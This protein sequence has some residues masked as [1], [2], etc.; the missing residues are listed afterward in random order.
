MMIGM[1]IAYGALCLRACAWL[2]GEAGGAE[3][4][5]TPGDFH[6]AFAAAGLLM[7]IS[8]AGYLRLPRDA[9]SGIGGAVRRGS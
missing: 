6:W 3:T 5:F 9:G 4:A 7:L 1:G 2:R 8:I